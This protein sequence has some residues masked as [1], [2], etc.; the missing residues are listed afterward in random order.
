MSDF[1]GRR[2][3]HKVREE[4]RIRAV[5]RVEAGESPEDVVKA[6]GFHRSRIYEWLAAYREG[7][8]EALRTRPI[9]GRPRKLDGKQLKRIYELVTR[10]NPLQLKFEF[11]L[12]TR[13]MVRELIR[14][15]YGV[16]LSEV[17][18]GRLLHKL[19][20]TPQRP[21]RRAYQQDEEAVERWKTEE[22][23]EIQKAA[24]RAKATIYFG[25]EAS[26]R[27]DYHSG[28][29]WAPKGRTPVVEST[30][31]RFTLNLISAVSAKGLLRFMTVEGRLTAAA[32]IGFLN[33]LIHNAE[34]PIFLIVDRHPVHR[35]ATVRDFVESTEGRLRL[36]FLPS[37]SPDL[38]PDELVW[39]H[40]KRHKVG[41]SHFKGPNQM[42]AV[43]MKYMRSLQRAPIVIRG[44]FKAPRV[45]Y[46]TA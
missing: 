45:R 12:W 20:L 46:A 28:T 37:Y 15:E 32:F 9:P 11:A 35:S 24:K 38:N 36:F 3:S 23:P 18:V 25:D 21:I 5:T 39:N 30:G 44:F 40:L 31:A 10:K 17:S 16:K 7:G 41:K 14:R 8:I 42:R 27:S 22:Y 6:L 33:R 26:V 13:G 29:T 1:D 19:G 2:L 43:V 4:I 34:N